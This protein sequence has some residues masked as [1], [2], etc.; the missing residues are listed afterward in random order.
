MASTMEEISWISPISR[1]SYFLGK[2]FTTRPYTSS[3][4][5]KTLCYVNKSDEE[6]NIAENFQGE[7]SEVET[8][9]TQ[10]GVE[11]SGSVI[12]CPLEIHATNA[13]KSELCELQ[14]ETQRKV[15]S[16]VNDNLD[17]TVDTTCLSSIADKLSLEMTIP[18]LNLELT[19]EM[20]PK[21][22]DINLELRTDENSFHETLYEHNKDTET[23]NP[24]STMVLQSHHLDNQT[25]II[26]VAQMQSTG[27]NFHS[28]SHDVGQ[29][30]TTAK[31]FIGVCKQIN[32]VSSVEGKNWLQTEFCHMN[33]QQ[34]RPTSM[35]MHINNTTTQNMAMNQFT[36]SQ[37]MSCISPTMGFTCVIGDSFAEMKLE[38]WGSNRILSLWL[39]CHITK[40][41]KTAVLKLESVT[42]SVK[43]HSVSYSK[44]GTTDTDKM[45]VS[46]AHDTDGMVS[47][48]GSRLLQPKQLMT[49][50]SAE[51]TQSLK[52]NNT[53]ASDQ[54]LVSAMLET[55]G[56]A[57]RDGSRQLEKM[58]LA[59]EKFSQKEQMT[60]SSRIGL[61]DETLALTMCDVDAKG[62][63]VGSW[64]LKLRQI[65]NNRVPTEIQYITQS[66]T[67]AV[68]EVLVPAVC[69]FGGKG[70]NVGS[71]QL[72][73][74]QLVS[75][76]LPT[77]TTFIAQSNTN[78]I[79]EALVPT[80]CDVDEKGPKVGSWTRE[81]IQ[82]ECTKLPKEIQST[83]Q[84]KTSASDETLDLAISTV[85]GKGLKVRTPEQMQL[86][87][88]K[89]SVQ[90]QAIP[91]NKNDATHQT[92]ISVKSEE[93]GKGQNG[94]LEVAQ[95]IRQSKTD[96]HMKTHVPAGSIA[97]GNGS[98]DRREQLQSKTSYSGCEKTKT[99]DTCKNKS[100]SNVLI[101]ESREKH[102]WKNR[103]KMAKILLVI[104][105]MACFPTLTDAQPTPATD[106]E[107]VDSMRHEIEL[108][109]MT[110]YLGPQVPLVWPE[111]SMP[112]QSH[113][114]SY[115]NNEST[116]VDEVNNF[117]F[118]Y[119]ILLHVFSC[120]YFVSTPIL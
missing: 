93:N 52:R 37:S 120:V 2:K 58:Q 41:K 20:Q 69:D 6:R 12:L 59:S 48:N 64:P 87:D 21:T 91:S 56:K 118:L 108:S 103:K 115:Y 25:S 92:L 76:E 35:I 77:E 46:S 116:V 97:D 72:Q 31:S 90:Q 22:S 98:N 110:E 18:L 30:M 79:D 15:Q 60:L 84:N 19:N 9:S 29:R 107:D 75:K 47:R 102:R 101:D 50:T 70:S 57:W 8:T 83:T 42:F 51:Q 74:R 113:M 38:M 24:Q 33:Y 3:S 28:K 63:K 104:I 5:P 17:T 106:L 54:T 55:D 39:S 95:L 65:E 11:S 43:H 85:D 16:S 23:F 96:A 67:D 78:V 10:N 117:L 73:I 68:D 71:G 66:K 99:D 89:Y 81:P 44:T 112:I 32:S 4:I 82:R 36:K 26:P 80:I 109:N 88:E 119:D 86:V 27:N 1:N 61:I 14:T 13:L 94:A 49:E 105:T 45:F 40:Y 111:Q 7:L 53:N 62:S 100:K 34:T 114:I